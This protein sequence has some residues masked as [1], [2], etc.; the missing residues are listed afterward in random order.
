MRRF[1]RIG[2]IVAILLTGPLAGCV[3][4]LVSGGS[5]D[6]ASAASSSSSSFADA[7][8]DIDPRYVSTA[9]VSATLAAVAAGIDPSR[10]FIPDRFEC[11]DNESADTSTPD[12]TVTFD[13]QET[14]SSALGSGRAVRPADRDPDTTVREFVGG[15]FD[16]ENTFIRFDDH[17]QSFEVDAGR[18][19]YHCYQAGASANRANRQFALNTPEA[20]DY[21]CRYAETGET[22][23]LMLNRDSTYTIGGQTGRFSVSDVVDGT[24][25]RIEFAGGPFDDERAFY[26]TEAESG[27]QSFN[28]STSTSFGIIPVGS[29]S[30][31]ALV[32][33]RLV[34]A[35]PFTEYGALDAPANEVPGVALAGLYVAD[36]LL[37][38][39]NRSYFRV[40]YY[41]FEPSGWIYR[42]V[43]HPVGIDCRRTHPNGLPYCE[44]YAVNG[45]TISIRSAIGEVSELPI[46][47]RGNR[48]VEIDGETAYPVGAVSKA[49]LTGDWENLSYTQSGC[50]GLGFCS[51]SFTRRLLAFSSDG[52][53]LKRSSG[54]S[55]NSF[56]TGIGSSSAFG[57]N[58]S[59]A[60]GNFE[61]DGNVLT[62]RYDN[63]RVRRHF[64][65]DPPTSV[66]AFDNLSYSVYSDD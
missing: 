44:R 66:I 29:S 4:E 22:V 30:E 48:V 26:S 61:L 2:R 17:G 12:L 65:S 19:E 32:C 21:A 35:R 36:D 60:V 37:S 34:P 3:S 13:G 14:Y 27:Y 38:S 52:R 23:S 10:A 58:N 16:G 28:V 47:I 6:D 55:I 41:R 57:S 11:H 56:D 51:S 40:S 1:S 24:S 5:S 46:S 42:D 45:D 31:L 25:S 20:A 43:P 39:V 33:E 63:G 64:V 54:Q 9:D 53:F 59:G 15:P 8:A 62:L 18:S 50:L 7:P 49:A